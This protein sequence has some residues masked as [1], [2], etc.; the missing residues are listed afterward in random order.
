MRIEPLCVVQDVRL[1]EC[2]SKTFPALLPATSIVIVFHN[3]AWSTLLRQTKDDNLLPPIL[4]LNLTNNHRG[5]LEWVR[6]Q[7]MKN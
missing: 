3:E 1:E 4:I 6:I 7:E 5:L 2:K